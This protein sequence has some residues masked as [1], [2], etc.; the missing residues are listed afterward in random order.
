MKT[1][2]LIEFNRESPRRITKWLP[3]K[4]LPFLKREEKRLTE[5]GW[6]AEIQPKQ[7]YDKSIAYALVVVDEG[8]QEQTKR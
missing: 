7:K 1:S 6:N 3:A 4:D 2:E 8:G 5:K